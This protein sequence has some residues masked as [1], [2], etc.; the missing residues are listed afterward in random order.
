MITISV[1]FVFA[2]LLQGL[3]PFIDEVG[4]Q[5]LCLYLRHCEFIGIVPAEELL[6]DEVWQPGESFLGPH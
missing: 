3:Q 5:F 4:K 2:F 1:T 6:P